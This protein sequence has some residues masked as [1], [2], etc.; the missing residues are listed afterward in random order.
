MDVVLK[1][2]LQLGAN[3]TVFIQ[4]GIF[5]VAIS[6]LTV[7]VYGPFFK[8]Y[9]QRLQQTKGADQVAY[10]TQDEAKKLDLIYKN[11]A[12]EINEKI[13]SIFEESRKIGTDKA[14]E[15]LAAAKNDVLAQ[16]EKARTQVESQKA[17]A[18]KDIAAVSAEV[19]NE[20]SKKL[21]G[22]V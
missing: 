15:T 17:S 18:Q 2:L 1:I 16:T 22:A 12:R 7:F 6:F 4:F 14:G 8:A 3:S 20:I 10:E 5:I 11:K 9:D 13:K 21:S 19:A